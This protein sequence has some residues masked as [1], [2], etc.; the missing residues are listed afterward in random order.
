M[1]LFRL[2]QNVIFV[3]IFFQ[4]TRKFTLFLSLSLALIRNVVVLL[5]FHSSR[6]DLR[7]SIIILMVSNLRV[8]F[9]HI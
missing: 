7:A 2:R 9:T 8:V 3:S 5:L 1:A 4:I 6:Q